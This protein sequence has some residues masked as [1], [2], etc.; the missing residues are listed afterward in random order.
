MDNPLESLEILHPLAEDPGTVTLTPEIYR[1]IAEDY[2]KLENFLSAITWY[3]RALDSTEDTLRK[4]VIQERILSITTLGW[5]TE[6]LLRAMELFPGGFVH[7]AVK[8]GIAAS[9][10]QYRQFRLAE[11]QLGR[12][13][14]QHPDDIFTPHIQALLDRLAS[15]SLPRV[16]TVG[17]LLP[18][19][20]KYARIGNNVLEALLLGA[21]AFRNGTENG[22]AIRLLIRNTQG[23]PEVAVER[24]GELAADPDVIGVVGPILGAVAKACAE[25]AQNLNL[26]MI[27]LTQREDV[28]QTGEFVFQN[29]LTARQQVDT[30]VDYT[31][32]D[33]GIT[34]FAVLYPDHVYGTLARDLL[35]EKVLDMGGEVTAAV[36]YGEQ[37]T[38]FQDEIRA[39]V[40]EEYLEEM[41]R[42]ERERKKEDP[43][44]EE[45]S[46]EGQGK[47]SDRMP[48]SEGPEGEGV[49][50]EEEI[51]KPLRPP[52]EALFV[53]DNYH[54]VSLIAPHLA[55]FDLNEIV[56]MGTN[57]WN[58]SHLVDE[59]GEY[60]R[61][62]VFVDGFF[63]NSEKPHVRDF[64][65][66]FERDFQ[67]V[68]RLF[69]AQGYDS[70]LILEEAFHKA[71]P[72]T[73]DRIREALSEMEGYP[74][75]SGYTDFD[76]GGA[77]RKRLYLLTVIRNRI[78][79]VY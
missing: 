60:V 54:R 7:E 65:E 67:R 23:N 62:S 18:L 11:M 71:V 5:E 20:G 49:W 47:A 45:E 26:P 59:A 25:E 9:Y 15:E 1:Y 46:P 10:Y 73:R 69:E 50:T 3:A 55:L 79:E 61:D 12:M 13:S 31:M 56:L 58:S 63:A 14:T 72:K 16:C 36:S 22:G 76:E 32:E 78:E 6:V 29:G 41:K 53:P 8:L 43:L 40:G 38:D 28:A 52:F 30:L 34:R 44:Q 33:L 77:S 74:G 64:V 35:T 27:T 57:A 70:L 42:R 4:E 19:T 21:R 75:L 66:E 17:C 48:G 37:E 24:L 68:P 2:L 51:E 39:L